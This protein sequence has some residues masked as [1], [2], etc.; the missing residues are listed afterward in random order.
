MATAQASIQ[1]PASP[2]QVWQLIGGFNSLPDWL[3]YIPKSELSEGG[4]V[5]TLANP[6]GDAIVERLVAFDHAAR[7]YSYTILQS[8]FPVSG[9]RSTLRVHPAEDGQRATVEW[10]GEF[11]PEGISDDAAS[12][13][14][15]GIYRDGLQAL[16]AVFNGSARG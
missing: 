10:S 2:E 15:G 8:P 3:P 13:L 5:R 1:I 6:N 9:Y 4:R 16:Q 14:F 7:S 11:V 12:Q